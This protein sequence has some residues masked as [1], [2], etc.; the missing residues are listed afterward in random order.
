MERFWRGKIPSPSIPGLINQ[1]N[2]MPPTED[3]HALASVQSRRGRTC[4]QCNFV[5]ISL[6]PAEIQTLEKG[7]D[8]GVGVGGR[9]RM[10]ERKADQVS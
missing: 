10:P 6:Y 3:S 4:L 5:I 9:A 2:H 1:A 7:G 8:D